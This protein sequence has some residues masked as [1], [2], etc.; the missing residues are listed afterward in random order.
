M[1]K[2]ASSTKAASPS[3]VAS[4][5][6]SITVTYDL[7]DLPTAQ[8]KAG[9]AGLLLQIDS[10]KN[11]K[12]PAPEYVWDEQS[13]TTKV[14]VTFTEETIHSLFDDLYAA[15][16]VEVRVK[17]KWANANLIRE[18]SSEE[19]V[20]GKIK[21]VKFFVYEVVQPSGMFL[22]QYITNSPEAWL[23]LWR[24][25]LWAI[26]RG[27][28]QS[29]QPFEQRSRGE[30][31][32]EGPS[33]W[34]DL[35]KADKAKHKGA[36]HTAPVA[37]SLWLGAQATNAENISFDG[38]VEQT[39]LL[40]F[41]CLTAMV[42]VPQVVSPDGDSEFV[43]YTLAIPDIVD[44]EEFLDSYPRMLADLG[45]TLRGFRPASAVIDLAAE[46]ALAYL[47]HM[48]RLVQGKVQA[49]ATRRSLGAVEFLHL[50]KIGNNIKT[51]SSGR[52]VPQ[53][54]LLKDYPLIVGKPG[55]KPPFSNPLFRRGLMLAMLE[56]V[57]WFRP[58]GKQFSEWPAHFFVHSDKSPPRLSWFW[59]DAR[60]KLSQET[61]RMPK[62]PDDPPPD[63]ELLLMTLV[64]KLVRSYVNDRAKSK[65]GV[66]LDK[67][68][69]GDKINWDALP[70]EFYEARRSVGESLF[71]EFRSRREQAFID[72]FAQT[73]F[74]AKQFLSD[75]HFTTI[76]HALL[77]RTE[78][79]KTLTLMSLSANS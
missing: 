27:N 73:L 19:T 37:G 11:R 4:E 29:R 66:N 58:F 63:P 68:K 49:N 14:A 38:R 44:L 16:V 72:H 67:F 59:A 25:M 61:D 26:P 35:Q 64:H 54:S 52:I 13:P 69:E 40:H 3:K 45:S 46:G 2:K 33:A 65:S 74:S 42:F 15:E 18:E 21:K 53:E 77:H 79:V 20:D 8:H 28:P 7:F 36:F 56:G 1:S 6:Q 41:W 76:G 51:L 50:A 30:P 5:P 9:L 71:L 55:E 57:P 43:G 60:K 32:K 34:E 24:D 78:D 47:D 75:E 23:K 48:T 62:L 39:I 31:C 70:K 10:M 12:K 22:K 17:S